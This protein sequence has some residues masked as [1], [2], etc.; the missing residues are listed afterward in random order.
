M[1]IDFNSIDE[2]VLPAFKGG[3]KALRARM[4]KDPLNT[5]LRGILKPGASI[6]MHTHDTGCEFILV[7]RGRGSVIC[8]GQK[9]PLREGELH[10]CPKG[11]SHSLINDS[12]SNLEFLGIVPQQ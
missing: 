2:S 10:Y 11:H 7:L 1:T 5:V 6:G 8:D 9:A 3:E 4:F 12:D